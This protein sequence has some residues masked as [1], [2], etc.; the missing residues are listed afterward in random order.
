MQ[1]SCNKQAAQA[2]Y[3]HMARAIQPH[4]MCWCT[5]KQKQCTNKQRK[6]QIQQSHHKTTRVSGAQPTN[7]TSSKLASTRG[8]LAQLHIH[9]DAVNNPVLHLCTQ[10]L[11]L[12]LQLWLS[13][14][15]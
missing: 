10:L 13:S 8:L 5:C 14:T 3:S 4:G 11:L 12:V 2:A 6:Q 9:A 1:P 7:A 15:L